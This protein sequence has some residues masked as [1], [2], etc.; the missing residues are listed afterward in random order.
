MNSLYNTLIKLAQEE[1][2]QQFKLKQPLIWDS[3]R[4]EV[5]LYDEYK[6]ICDTS[7]FYREGV[8]YFL[9]DGCSSEAIIQDEKRCGL[10]YDRL[11]YMKSEHVIEIFEDPLRFIRKIANLKFLEAWDD[12]DEAENIELAKK[13]TLLIAEKIEANNLLVDWYNDLL[14]F[15]ALLYL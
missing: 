1:S 3:T 9:T 4:V 6:P 12:E 10:F 13:M 14:K 15:S 8:G 7:R 5:S 2:N 11:A